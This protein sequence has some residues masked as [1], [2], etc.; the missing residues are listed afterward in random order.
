MEKNKTLKLIKYGHEYCSPCRTLK[1]ILEKISKEYIDIVDFVDVDTYKANPDDVLNA[2]IRAVP[3][4][5]LLKDNQEIWR[6]VGFVSEQVIVDK[7]K[8]NI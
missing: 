1:P 6:Q 7:I 5:I 8:E 4:I 2:Q 3:T